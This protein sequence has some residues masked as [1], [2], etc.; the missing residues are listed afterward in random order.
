MITKDKKENSQETALWEE[1][2]K[3]Q[4]DFENFIRT[5]EKP[6]NN[7]ELIQAHLQFFTLKIAKINLKIK[8]LSNCECK[9]KE[10]KINEEKRN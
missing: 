9:E 10:T 6:K 4:S 8:E 5:L 3:L 7:F 2:K 1:L